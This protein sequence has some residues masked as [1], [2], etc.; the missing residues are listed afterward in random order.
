MKISLQ[1]GVDIAE[2]EP[3][4][5]SYDTKV[6]A[7]YILVVERYTWFAH[8]HEKQNAE[9]TLANLQRAADTR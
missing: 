2:N 6:D 7:L 5:V 1:M 4:E 3:T 9:E 8:K